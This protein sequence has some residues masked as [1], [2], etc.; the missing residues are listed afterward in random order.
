MLDCNDDITADLDFEVLSFFSESLSKKKKK[1]KQH[2]KSYR[3]IDL[4]IDSLIG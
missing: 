4:L 2:N 1:K 3:L